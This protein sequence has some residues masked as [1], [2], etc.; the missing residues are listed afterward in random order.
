MRW[1]WQ[2]IVLLPALVA[3]MAA[4]RAD[5]GGVAPA[6]YFET[7]YQQAL[8]RYERGHWAGA[9]SALAALADAGH[10]AAARLALQMWRHGPTLYGQRFVA[11]PPRRERWLGF[12]LGE[13]A[14]G[15]GQPGPAGC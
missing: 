13:G 2:R 4:A 14:E 9:W 10:P 3:T 8:D 12:A 7:A 11:E 5:G 6:G 15:P 1:R